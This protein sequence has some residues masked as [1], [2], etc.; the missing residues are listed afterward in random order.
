MEVMTHQNLYWTGKRE[1][2]QKEVTNC[3]TC[4]RTKRLNIKYSKL[5]AKEA[6]E[7]PQNKLYV[8]LIV[9]YGTRKKG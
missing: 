9:H 7:I 5:P 4:Q 1:S 3:D 6:E 2:F 8:D